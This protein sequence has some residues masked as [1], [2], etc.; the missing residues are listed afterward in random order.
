MGRCE[1]VNRGAACRARV[2]L[3]IGVSILGGDGYALGRRLKQ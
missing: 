1:R 3:H 2:P